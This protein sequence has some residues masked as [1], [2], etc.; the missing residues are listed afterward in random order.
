MTALAE[1]L[2][3]STPSPLF[4]LREGV[5][6]DHAHVYASWL[7]AIEGRC[8]TRPFGARCGMSRGR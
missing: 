3:P 2:I 7:H 4:V 5:G 8:S 6:A 1:I